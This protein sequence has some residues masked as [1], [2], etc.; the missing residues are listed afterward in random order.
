[1]SSGWSTTAVPVLT[2]NCSNECR[3]LSADFRAL[4]SKYRDQIG[5]QDTQA[6]YVACHWKRIRTRVR[7][8]VETID[9]GIE[10]LCQLKGT[11]QSQLVTLQAQQ[12]NKNRPD[13]GSLRSLNLTL[14]SLRVGKSDIDMGHEPRC[15]IR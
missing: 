4:S 1:M 10:R 7:P 6:H 2:Q 12:W 14:E 3:A 5:R 15:N 11:L 9:V 13:H 8:N